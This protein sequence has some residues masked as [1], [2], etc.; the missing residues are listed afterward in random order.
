[1]ELIMDCYIEKMHDISWREVKTDYS[2][3]EKEVRFGI[4]KEIILSLHPR[5]ILDVG[6]GSGYLAYLL[7]EHNSNITIHGLDVSTEALKQAKSLDKKYKLDINRDNFPEEESNFDLVVCSEVLE[8]LIDV[9]HCLT[10]IC[11]VLNHR[12][13][14]IVTVPNFSFWRFRIDALLGRIPYVV[15][16]ERH[17]QIF[18]QEL[19]SQKLTDAGFKVLKIIGIRSRLKFLLK[20]STSFF[21]ETLIAVASKNQL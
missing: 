21:S 16:D 20:T 12:G 8:H 5:A 17:L 2:F 4:L 15:Y 10:E 11:R 9:R 3:Y 18:N 14:L 6:C 1:M 7:K 13:K 19:L